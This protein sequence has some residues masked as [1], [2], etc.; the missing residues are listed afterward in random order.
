MILRYGLNKHFNTICKVNRQ[1][2]EAEVFL[3]GGLCVC[4]CVCARA[5]IAATG[6]TGINARLLQ[7]IKE[8]Q[9]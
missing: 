7:M 9:E 1:S 3:L 4:V 5:T 2:T 8:M 6:T